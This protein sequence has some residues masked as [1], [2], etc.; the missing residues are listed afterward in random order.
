MESLLKIT[1]PDP[2][3][4][5]IVTAI[6]EILDKDKS[7]QVIIMALD[8]LS[9]TVKPVTTISGCSF[10]NKDPMPQEDRK[11][12]VDILDQITDHYIGRGPVSFPDPPDLS[13]PVERDPCPKCGGRLGLESGGHF[14]E[15]PDHPDNLEGEDQDAGS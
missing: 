1:N 13:D 8:V 14:T 3:G 7:D 11:R 6:L 12:I 9:R 4:S 10:V 5:P 15:C 2:D